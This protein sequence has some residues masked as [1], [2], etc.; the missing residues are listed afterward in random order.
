MNHVSSILAIGDGSM[1]PA[2]LEQEGI[3]RSS[4]DVFVREYRK[5]GIEEALDIQQRA[6]LHPVFDGRR[7]FV[8]SVPSMTAEAQNALL[9]TIEEPRANSVFYFLTPSPHSL[10]PT[11]QSRSQTMEIRGV[12]SVASIVD[13]NAFLGATY[14]K[15]LEMLKPLYDHED[16]GRDIGAVIAFLAAMERKFSKAKLTP[17]TEEGVRAV[18]RAR[19]YATDKGSL[20]KSL[21]EQVAL[22]APRI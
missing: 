21:L 17:E 11:V 8:M 19:K 22:L 10:L 20:L 18:Y 13:I 3:N 9:K 4:P 7:V 1:I 14:E 2:L 5:F 15:R 16:E 12:E 6:T